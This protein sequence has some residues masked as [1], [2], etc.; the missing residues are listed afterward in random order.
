[1][2]GGKHFKFGPPDKEDAFPH[3]VS[4][5]CGEA[6]AT[7]AVYPVQRLM[8]CVRTE[9]WEQRA[10]FCS[11]HPVQESRTSA[12]SF[13]RVWPANACVLP[14]V[15][16]A[17]GSISKFGPQIKMMRSPGSEEQVGSCT[18]RRSVSSTTTAALRANGPEGRI[19]VEPPR[20]GVPHFSAFIF[21][22]LARPSHPRAALSR[23]EPNRPRHVTSACIA[24]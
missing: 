12:G 11:R 18:D 20:A 2:G 13:L 23:C 15:R 14:R 16:W 9:R 6:T 22:S 5:A 24:T 7:V 8:P 10:E 3:G 4:T 17:A 19:L 21:E 1:M